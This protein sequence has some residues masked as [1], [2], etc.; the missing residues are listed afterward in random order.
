VFLNLW[1][2]PL[3]DTIV[4]FLKTFQLRKTG[5]EKSFRTQQTLKW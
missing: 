2:K 1:Q 4:M 3:Q 5:Y